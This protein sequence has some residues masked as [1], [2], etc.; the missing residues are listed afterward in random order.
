MSKQRPRILVLYYTQSGQLRDILTSI[1]S[2]IRDAADITFAEILP[3]TPFGLPWK[4]YDFFNAM[5]ES[6]ARTPIAVKPLPEAV[7]AR[8]YDLILLGYQPWFLHPSQPVTGFLFGP[9]AQRLFAGK[10]VLTVVGS[11][12]MWLNAQERI[13]EDLLRLGA[14][15]VGN[16]VLEDSNSNIVSLLTIIRWAFQGQK[17]ASRFLPEAGVQQKDIRAAGR[18]GPVILEALQGDNLEGLHAELMKSGAVRLLPGLI[19]LEKRGITNFRKFSKWIL[20]KGGPESEARRGRV[21]TFQWLLT[22]L[23]FVFSPLSSLTA[24]IQKQVQKKKLSEEV[25]Y[26]KSLRYEAGRI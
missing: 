26:F 15:L 13:K 21:K 25:D 19:V 2:G 16:I 10:P 6:V 24:V 5:P 7:L 9:D 4:G 22:T 12:N 17:E 1:T 11:R 3:E 20:E 14:R 23:V 8:D 18:F